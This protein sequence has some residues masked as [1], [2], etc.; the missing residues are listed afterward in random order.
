MCPGISE[1]SG[2]GLCFSYLCLQV[3]CLRTELGRWPGCG[4]SPSC[5]FYIGRARVYDV[6]SNLI[7]LSLFWISSNPSIWNCRGRRLCMGSSHPLCWHPVPVRSP[8]I[9]RKGLSLLMVSEIAI[10]GQLGPETGKARLWISWQPGL[11]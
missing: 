8:L 2:Q 7:L 5:T 10:C 6:T 3:L 4:C 1:L 11:E 9:R